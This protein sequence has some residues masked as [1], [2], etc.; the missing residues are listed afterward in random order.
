[1]RGAHCTASA[2]RA[3]K[4]RVLAAIRDNAPRVPSDATHALLA[5]AAQTLSNRGAFS[6]SACKSAANNPDTCW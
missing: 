3:G 5:G 2:G 4:S 1:M 6:T